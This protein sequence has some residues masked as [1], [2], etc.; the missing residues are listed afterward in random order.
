MVNTVSEVF[1]TARAMLQGGDTSA[2]IGFSNTQMQQFFNVAYPELWQ[3]MVQAQSPR[4]RREFFYVV[5]AYTSSVDPIAIG[6]TDMAE[7][8]EMFER[9]SLTSV[10]ITST[11]TAS[12]IQVTATAAHGIATNSDVTVSGVASTF[13]PWGRWFWTSTGSTTG[14]LNGSVSDGV[15]GTGGYLVTTNNVFV[16][17]WPRRDEWTDRPLSNRLLDWGWQ[18]NLLQFRG[19]NQDAQIHCYYWASGTPPTNVNTTLNID[20]CMA[21]L[22]TRVAA[23][24]AESRGWYVMADRLNQRALGPKGEADGSGGLLRSFLNIQ[25]QNL[26]R[27]IFIKPAFRSKAGLSITGDYIYGTFTYSGGGG[28]NVSGCNRTGW[29]RVPITN[30]NAN[31]DLT[32]GDTQYIALTG[33]TTILNYPSPVDFSYRL[34]ID[35]DATGGRVLT[36]GDQYLDVNPNDFSGVGTPGNTRVIIQFSVN[37]D[38]DSVI[39]GAITGPTPL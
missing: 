23:L 35:Q 10:P 30:G 3:I 29:Y 21:F 32:Q 1:N 38:G 15:A 13:A 28:D 39:S 18:D 4:V 6:V 16:P 36:F 8:E 37:T 2:S 12:P 26:Q 19:A 22:S 24:A 27:N 14:T 20:D 31:V 33:N 11:N 5:P 9:G 17:M 34:V 7:P 25:V